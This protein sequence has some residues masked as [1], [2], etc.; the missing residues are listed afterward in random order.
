MLGLMQD[1]PLLCHKILDHAAIAHPERK[2]VTRSIEGPMHRT[3]YR[4]L[5]RRS[6]Q[7]A[8]RLDADGIVLGDRCATLGWNTWRHFELWYALG[9][10]GA[11][12]HT[13]NPRLFP[14]QIAWIINHAEDRFLFTDITFMPLVEKLLPALKTIEKVIVLTDAAHMPETALPNVVP[15]EE[16]LAEADDDFAWKSLRREHR[17][18]PLLHLRHHRRAEGR[19]L[20]APLQRAARHDGGYA[21]HVRQFGA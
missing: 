16:W 4:E 1:W 13:V 8:K 11:V 7:L 12:C 15:Y 3:N 5:R 14:D 2:V 19:R 17:Q 10:I 6:L 21:R 18:R 9:G 20:F